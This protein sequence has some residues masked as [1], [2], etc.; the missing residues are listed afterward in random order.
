MTDL[1]KETFPIS[2][3]II[4]GNWNGKFG[5]E[6]RDSRIYQE[7]SYGKPIQRY[8]RRKMIKGKSTF[9]KTSKPTKRKR[10]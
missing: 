4:K 6:R 8:Y 9:V 5:K 3:R 7:Q 1:R 2:Y 10:R